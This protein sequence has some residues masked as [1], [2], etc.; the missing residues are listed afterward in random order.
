MLSA[1]NITIE[2]QNANKVNIWRKRE[3]KGTKRRREENA[4]FFF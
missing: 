2:F 4:F 3:R 1:K